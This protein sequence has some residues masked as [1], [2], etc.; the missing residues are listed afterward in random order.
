MAE[1]MDQLFGL[2]REA[3]IEIVGLN[4][5]KNEAQAKVGAATIA[6]FGSS[7]SGFIYFEPCTAY[8][9]KRPPDVL[10]CHPEVGILVIEVKGYHI[11]QIQE[12][13]AG[14][15]Y[16]KNNGFIKSINPFRQAEDAMFDIINAVK[17]KAS[18]KNGGPLSNAL[19]S[20]PHIS[21]SD[22]CNKGFENSLPEKFLLLKD[23]ISDPARFRERI[24]KIVSESL[25]ES[26]KSKPL[27]VEQIQSIKLAFGDSSV[28]NDSRKPKSPKPKSLGAMIDEI[29]FL[30]KNLSA[31]QQELSR[32]EI[33]GFPRLI[34]GVAG[35][36]K[37]VVLANMAARYVNRH[38]NADPLFQ[39]QVI[40]PRMVVLCFNRSLVPFIRGKISDSFRQQTQS[41][42]PHN[43]P[44]VKHLNKFIYDLCNAAPRYIRYLSVKEGDPASRALRYM[45]MIT[46]LERNDEALYKNLLYEVILV[47]EGQDLVPEEFMLLLKMIKIDPITKEK[48]LIIF[49]DDAQNLYARPRPIWKNIGIDVQRGDRSRVMKQCFR[50]TREV[51]DL[52]FN[53][54]VG[55]QAPD[56]QQ[57]RTRTF[58]DVNELKKQGLVEETETHFRVKFTDRSSMKPTVIPFASREQEK[59][60]LAKEV[61]RLIYDDHVR[62]EDILVLFDREADFHDLSDII[63]RYDTRGAI[64]GFIKP[65]N[66]N[67]KD[68][69][70]YIFRENCLTISTTKG[71]KGYDAYLVFL[72]GCDL[73][74]TENSGRASFYVGSTRSKLVLWAT[75]LNAATT[76]L[77]ESLDLGNIL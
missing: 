43:T 40:P 16:C 70:N 1:Y 2:A 8:S 31:E 49:Y 69:D 60:W 4:D 46:D 61:V 48:N 34:R 14:S 6:G 74:N 33:K 71:A 63:R 9:T 25:K 27:S 50:N 15:L 23:D 35:S 39:A 67:H 3:K 37:T 30:D 42:L 11:D 58:A 75:G 29:A 18:D 36:G 53:V 65:F 20:L 45:E 44:E 26:K 72:A 5:I 68:Q 59:N 62:P 10:I 41:E 77:N 21:K 38:M 55:K 7:P 57:V 76:L 13:K 51:L 22:L 64:H 47:D 17:R 54:L 73:F 52:A 12:I 19:V 28:I 32:I 24:Q 56:S 66:S